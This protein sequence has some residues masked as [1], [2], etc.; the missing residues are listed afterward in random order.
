MAQATQRSAVSRWFPR[1]FASKVK[2]KPVLPN[3]PTGEKAW[4]SDSAFML[5]GQRF[6]PWN[7]DILLRSK[8]ADVYWK[9]LRD[10]QV[11]AA[12]S[13][14]IGTIASRSWRFDVPDSEAESAAQLEE[15]AQ[16]FT[17]VM[18]N[19]LRGTPQQMFKS[20][21]SSKATGYSVSEMVFGPIAYDG[22]TRWGLRAVKLRPFHTFRW[23][24]DAY[25][26][27]Q[28]LIQQQG[29]QATV[30]DP[31][32]FI[33]HVTNPHIDPVFGES[34]LRAAYRP[35]WEKDN[36]LKFWNIYLERL[37]GG[38]A[39]GTVTGTLASTEREALQN[40]L[41]N[42][43]A[44]TGILL[45][46]GV[47]LD[48]KLPPSTDAFSHAV[49]DRNFAI[50]RAL[51]MPALL[52][53]AP[54]QRTG[55]RAQSETQQE[56]FLQIMGM[57]GDQL[58][59]TLNEQVFRPL[60]LW[61]FGVEEFPKLRFDVF[62]QAQKR[63]IVEAWLAAVAGGAVHNLEQDEVRTRDL[64]GYNPLPGD[65]DWD[66]ENEKP[67][68]D[69]NAAQ[70]EP[71]TTE[72]PKDAKREERAEDRATMSDLPNMPAW[73][74]SMMTEK[75]AKP[76]I[77][78]WFSRFDA[79]RAEIG[80]NTAQSDMERALTGHTAA[81]ADAVRDVIAEIVEKI[82]ANPDYE[83]IAS[84][85]SVAIPPAMRRALNESIRAGLLAGYDHG[86]DTAAQEM[87]RASRAGSK[88]IADRIVLAAKT[89]PRVASKHGP[90]PY[91][92]QLGLG[93]E[94]AERY[95]QAKAFE[96]TGVISEAILNA[97]KQVLLD[98]IK[99]ER[100]L[101]EIIKALEAVLA[102]LIPPFDRAGREVNIPAR[103]AT[104]VRTNLTDAFNQAR[105]SVYNDPSIGDFVVA[106][107]YSAIL[108]GRTTPFCE[109][110]DGKIYLK[111]DPIWKSI[112][113]PNHFNCR[114][115]LIPITELDE[116][117]EPSPQPPSTV[118]PANGFS[119]DDP[120]ELDS[121]RSAGR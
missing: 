94:A 60:A 4:A 14:I 81:M 79:L 5:L 77:P 36:I 102:D 92:F 103:L 116:G 100:T 73:L 98:G 114:S 9:M 38:L 37:A 29:S 35:Y 78:A 23:R 70:V 19:T 68:V 66:A 18:E 120:S 26:N 105:L 16:F 117:W 71:T 84:K 8:G 69:S 49:A 111:A 42:L 43:S 74:L 87:E 10:D 51:L 25:G 119:T 12:Y 39:I 82:A 104:I 108:D 22:Q 50:T 55:A 95:I 85:M 27:V 86:R 1:W 34:D 107:E 115:V 56:S 62:T 93:I 96:I 89:A 61:N 33:I 118:Q 24:V 21:L 99:N 2:D 6:E 80:L 45:P 63:A 72:S 41:S 20:V 28:E 11:K 83:A 40:V 67:A 65:F 44:S 54:E 109:R 17:Y 47:A 64:L 113:P 121:F 58:A 30:L 13:F 48:V 76:S 90:S 112:T 59:D 32:K 97:A 15:I 52:G 7:P 88:E 3:P 46:D 53:L 106:Y 110:T 31:R 57:E 75:N 101:S 91:H